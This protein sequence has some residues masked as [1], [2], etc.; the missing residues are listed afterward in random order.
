MYVHTT[1][2]VRT[3]QVARSLAF[4]WQE[5]CAILEFKIGEV[6]PVELLFTSTSRLAPAPLE[7]PHR[8][9]AVE[10]MKAFL[11][12]RGMELKREAHPW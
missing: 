8:Q 6:I 5:P 11:D 3:G 12:E 7:S 4:A 10:E 2:A 9:A 1:A